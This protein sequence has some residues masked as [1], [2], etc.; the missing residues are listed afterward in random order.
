MQNFTTCSMW[1]QPSLIPSQ[2][3][4]PWPYKQIVR[5]T[6]ISTSPLKKGGE[7]H[8]AFIFETVESCETEH[9]LFL[10]LY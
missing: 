3:F 6:V 5:M 9:L 7:T 10:A 8:S 2:F 1:Q 4:T